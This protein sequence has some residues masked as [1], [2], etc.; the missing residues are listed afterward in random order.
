MEHNIA[1]WKSEQEAAQSIIDATSGVHKP[2]AYPPPTQQELQSAGVQNN[3]SN[4]NNNNND[5]NNDN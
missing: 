3:G 1:M 4:N 5:H 2:E